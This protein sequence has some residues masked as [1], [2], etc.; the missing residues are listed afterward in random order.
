[1][2]PRQH[3]EMARRLDKMASLA[4][5]K[6]KSR[7]AGFAQ[8]HR[9]VARITATRQTA[10]VAAPEFDRD[11]YRQALP[12]FDASVSSLA[13]DC[14]APRSIVQALI[15]HLAASGLDADEVRYVKP[16]IRRFTEDM[17]ARRRLSMHQAAARYWNA[18]AE[19]QPLETVWAQQMFPLPQEDMDMALENE[20]KRLA[21]ET[22]N[23]ALASAYLKIMPLLWESAAITNYLKSNPSLRAA[24][25]PIASIAEATMI[26]RK[27]FSL[28][29]KELATL[30]EMLKVPPT[31]N[32]AF[33]L[34]D[35]IVENHRAMVRKQPHC[36]DRAEMPR[37]AEAL[38]RPSFEAET[39]LRVTAGSNGTMIELTSA[40]S[41][42]ARPFTHRIV[43]PPNCALDFWT[44]LDA[45]LATP[46]DSE[47]RIG[48]DGVMIKVDCRTP[49]GSATFEVWSP[50][51][52]THAGRLIR[53]IYDLAWETSSAASALECLEQLRSYLRN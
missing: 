13:R 7:L 9:V 39:S 45:L 32:R 44:K 28:T 40:Q 15:R 49:V 8:A 18:I 5:G 20:E 52:T 17:I 6:E 29:T 33:L 51:T 2:D 19:S 14:V 36:R 53:L 3:L 30:A 21:R 12:Y 47:T 25:R 35:S 22:S 46:F 10:N 48:L 41:F 42:F 11:V 31:S 23:P 38:F 50:E 4:A 37:V 27:D 24:I 34:V 26:A 16:Y 43:V 1:M